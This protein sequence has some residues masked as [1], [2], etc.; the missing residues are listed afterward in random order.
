MII[1][2][3]YCEH[4]Y[5]TFLQLLEQLKH[6]SI[7]YSNCFLRLNFAATYMHLGIQDVP[8]PVLIENK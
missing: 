5:Y 7:T 8:L 4:Q 1:A 2:C 6:Y 3:D